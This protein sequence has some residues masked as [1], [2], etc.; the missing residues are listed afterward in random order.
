M[1][2]KSIFRGPDAKHYAVVHR[3]QRDPLINDP[4]AGDRVLYEVERPNE[5]KSKRKHQGQSRSELESSLGSQT[6]SIRPNVGEATMYDIFYDDSEYDYMQHLKPVGVSKDAI[7][8]NKPEA[9]QEKPKSFGLREEN[10]SSASSSSSRLPNSV[11]PTPN[12]QILSYKDHLEFALPSNSALSDGLIPAINDPS[13]RE[14]MEALEDDA[15]VEEEANDAF[16]GQIVKDGERDDGD[17]PEWINELKDQ[18]VELTQWDRTVGQFKQSTKER[19]VS[20]DGRSDVSSNDQDHLQFSRSGKDVG[21]KKSGSSQFG[22]KAGSAFSMSS[23]AMYRNEGLSNLDDR[24]DKIEKEYEDSDEDSDTASENSNQT[25][26]PNTMYEEREDFEEIMNDFLDRFEVLGGKM[27]PILKGK[28]PLEKLDTLRKEILIEDEDRDEDLERRLMKEKI[29]IRLDEEEKKEMRRVVKETEV[30]EFETIEDRHNKWD[31]ESI[32]STYSNVE[33]HPR[34]I[35]IRDTLDHVKKQTEVATKVEIDRLTGFPVVNGQIVRGTINT[36]ETKDDEEEDS[37]D[38]SD[39]ETSVPIRETIKRDRNEDKE[40]K[41]LRKAEVKMER[42]ARRQ[43]K[44]NTKVSFV[45][46]RN[47]QQKI[48]QRLAIRKASDVAGLGGKSIVALL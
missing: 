24:F 25:A 37:D 23:S 12:E 3:S 38:D 16:F 27:K 14:I 10:P 1:A 15:F 7:L 47:K 44:K 46:E 32:L 33:N 39:A 2:P 19:Q 45:D 9:R 6:T 21:K 11:L 41:K 34:V 48:A 8:L 40:S 30:L 42:A 4:E 18:P 35:R 26:T 13:I 43:E 22:S 29:L 28:T 31:C 5:I 20:D 17:E 36:Q